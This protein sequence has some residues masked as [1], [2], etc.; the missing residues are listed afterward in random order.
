MAELEANLGKSG[1]ANMEAY[2]DLPSS[3]MPISSN[4]LSRL[5]MD[6]SLVCQDSTPIEQS[7]QQG[8]KR[9]KLT[10]MV[11]SASLIEPNSQSHFPIGMKQE[12]DSLTQ[13]LNNSGTDRNPDYLIKQQMIQQLLLRHDVK[14]L[15]DNSSHAKALIQNQMEK[16]LLQ[17]KLLSIRNSSGAHSAQSEQ[18][19]KNQLP[20]Q[21]TQRKLCIQSSDDDSCSLRLSQY[22]HNLQYRPKDNNIVYWRKFVSEFFAPGA[23]ESWCF[24]SYE[25]IEQKVLGSMRTM[26]DWC[27]DICGTN[28][29]KGFEASFEILSRLFKMKFD[30]GALGEILYLEFP[31][32]CRYSSGIMMLEYEN[33]A[34]ESIYEQFRVLSMRVNFVLFSGM[35]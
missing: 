23:I 29:G 8:H 1:S 14:Q 17:Q 28:S 9:Q 27:C 30:S 32:E 12:P 21:A 24:S 3:L 4:N 10:Q 2:L 25:N 33:A 22:M 19:M 11:G 16:Q 15:Q 20:Q 6:A 5:W 26:D 35:T 34:Q 7:S 31:R 18:Q 13:L